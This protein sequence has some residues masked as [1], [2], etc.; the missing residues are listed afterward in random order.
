MDLNRQNGEIKSELIE[1]YK[2]VIDSS[3]FCSGLFVKKFESHMEKWLQADYVSA[4]SSGTAALLLAL[5]A[6]GI[7]AND[8]VI[9]PAN[10]FIATAWAPVYLGAIPVFVDCN[11][12]TANIDVID[13]EK[14]ITKNTKCIIGV[15]MYGNPFD[16]SSIM[17]I[18]KRYSIHVVEDCAQAFGSKYAGQYVGTFGA[19]GCFSFY[20]TKNLGAHGEAGAVVT[21]EK[22]CY[23]TI[24]KLRNHGSQKQYYHDVIGF[25]MRMDGIQ[26][27]VLNTKLNHLKLWEKR[28]HY[29]SDRYD[30]E[31]QNKKVKHIVKTECASPVYHL[32]VL[33][34]DH[35]KKFLRF[36]EDK[37]VGYG[38]HYPLCCPYQKAFQHLRYQYG[39]F[40]NAEYLSEH[41]VSIPFFVGLSDDEV[42]IIIEAINNY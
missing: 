31:I 14:K 32:Y 27:A 29:I 8:E 33:K 18:A 21:S 3:E 4:C 7:K 37:G 39:S 5:K 19:A 38:L 11:L 23:E 22:G 25:N 10:T 2:N 26:G 6:L 35:R 15:H 40:P 41:I 9:V 16:I 13:L 17:E 20:P 42:S 28:K 30:C 1:A 36:L 12:D 24:M 34:V